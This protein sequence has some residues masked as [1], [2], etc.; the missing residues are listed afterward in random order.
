MAR[1]L[2]TDLS[3]VYRQRLLRLEAQAKAREAEASLIE[4]VEQ[5]VAL[6]EAR[7]DEYDKPKQRRGEGRKPVRR[8]DGLEW[9]LSQSR[10]TADQY[11]AGKRYGDAFR[12]A[13]PTAPIRSILNRDV[14]S[15][16][17][18]SVAHLLAAAEERVY[19]A[20]KLAMYRRQLGDH[21]HLT[22]VCDRVC[23]EEKTPRQ[24]A[25]NGRGAEA[26]EAVLVIALDLLIDHLPAKR[27][28]L[29]EAA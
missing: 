22:S 29:A 14:T 19:A 5:T 1:K 7:G 12:K 28:G 6:G 27:G 24:A 17:G 16:G 13:I 8:L 20:E 10:I 2:N 15:G 25:D 3:H 11:E 18:C 21:R 9:M 23:G 26:V 4:S